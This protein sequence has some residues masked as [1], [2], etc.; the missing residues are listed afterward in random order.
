MLAQLSPHEE[1]AL[2]EIG[3]GSAD[4]LEPAHL[5]RL[6]DLQLIEWTGQTDPAWRLTA[7]GQQRYA[8]LVVDTGR[9]SFA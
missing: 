9:P 7:R 6:L 8:C 2:R 3:F 1:T 5:R 4:R